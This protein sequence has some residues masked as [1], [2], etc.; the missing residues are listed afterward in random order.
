MFLRPDDVIARFQ[1]GEGMT[2]ADLGVGSGRYALSA[3]RAVG[4]TGAVYGC[5][6]NKELLSRLSAEARHEK[7]RN[8]HVVR[9]DLEEERGTTLA[10]D[11]MHAVIAANILFQI[12]YKE[13]FM[14]E[15]ARILRPGGK[16]LIVDWSDSFGGVGPH[17]G[18]VVRRHVAHALA[19]DSGLRFEKDVDAGLHHYGMI[20]RKPKLTSN[21]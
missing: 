19:E 3:A 14:R 9:T 15:I 12:E 16:V 21:S 7:V 5:D 13:R 4:E 6:V 1:L 11:S 20:F 10:D 2:V 17:A 8:V 18:S